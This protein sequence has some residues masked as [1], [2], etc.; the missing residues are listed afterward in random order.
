MSA[1][2]IRAALSGRLDALA[3]VLTLPIAW[4]GEEFD[5]TG[6]AF[7]RAQIFRSSTRRP[8]IQTGGDHIGVGIL[9]VTVNQ[10]MGPEGGS[11]AMAADRIA[12]RVAAW[13]PEDLR[14]PVA[15]PFLRII[16]MPHVAGGFP[17]D[18]FWV[19]PVSIEFEASL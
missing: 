12:D 17:D 10:P 5:P 6:A 9:Q 13:F 7:L 3:T 18:A 14:L 4:E 16:R 11:P 15:G 1:S 8:W 2:E 19:V